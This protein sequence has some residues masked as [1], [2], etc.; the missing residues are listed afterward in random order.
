MTLRLRLWHSCVAAAASVTLAMPH[1]AKGAVRVC[2]APVSSTVVIENTEMAGKRRA[3]D[4]WKAKASYYGA[5]YTSWRLATNKGLVCTA[6]MGQGHACIARGSPC[7]IKQVP[8]L[9]GS[10]PK[11]IPG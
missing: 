5:G 3:L 8:P 9:T 2:K 4:E 6:V 1:P 7:I 10:G 11:P